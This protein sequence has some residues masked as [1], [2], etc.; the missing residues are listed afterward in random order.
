M[1]LSKYKNGVY[2]IYYYDS[3]GKRRSKST[4]EKIKAKAYKILNE[5]QKSYEQDSE[6]TLTTIS[7]EH[8][9]IKFLAYSETINSIS[10]TKAIHSTLN[11]IHAY[12]GNILLADLTKGKV[13]SYTR[14]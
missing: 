14:T 12:F 9:K 6:N 11:G 5:F 10:H 2:Y 8:F 4:K 13:Q 1:F 7:L 3:K